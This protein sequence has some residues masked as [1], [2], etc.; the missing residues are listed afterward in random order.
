MKGVIFDL[1]GTLL[2]TLDDIAR[3]CNSVLSRI[4]KRTFTPEEYR[5]WIGRGMRDLLVKALGN[6]EE[7]DAL[8]KTLFES[9]QQNPVVSTVPYP[10]IEK[11]L[12]EL[13]GRGIPLAVLSNKAEE[14]VRSIIA[15]SLPDY[16][17][18]FVHGWNE[19]FLAKPDP[20][21][22]IDIA[23]RMQLNPDEIIFVG[24]SPVDINTAKNANMMAVAVSWGF[25][26]VE[27]IQ[28]A[29]AV[30]QKPEELLAFFGEKDKIT[31]IRGE[32]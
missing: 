27:E 25:G 29:D 8:W 4:G 31:S 19:R 28:K 1:D 30:L 26:D 21:Q 7:L 13:N 20:A 15:I 32:S 24:D 3:V 17:F 5:P 18:S 11:L 14:L 16:T 12:G 23:E 6:E 2:D 10:G 9:Y 22:A